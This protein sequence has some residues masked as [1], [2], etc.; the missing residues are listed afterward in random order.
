MET[1]VKSKRGDDDDGLKC[2]FACYF[3]FHNYGGP[4]SQS[5]RDVTYIYD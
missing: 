1:R 2:C 3:I 5:L 4:K